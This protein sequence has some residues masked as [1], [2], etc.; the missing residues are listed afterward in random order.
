[1]ESLAFSDL[2]SGT[3]NLASID[4]KSRNATVVFL[5][6]Y[7]SFYSS[8]LKIFSIALDRCLMITYPFKHRIL[9]SKGKI[10][11]WIVFAWFLSSIHSLKK[12][13]QRSDSDIMVLRSGIA[14][15]LIILTAMLYF[16]IKTYFALRL[17]TSKIHVKGKN[18]QSSC[19]HV[20]ERN[21]KLILKA[22]VNIKS[23]INI[24][25][26][27]ISKETHNKSFADVVSLTS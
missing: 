24:K 16:I 3:A 23:E 27:N 13:L 14:L 11:V 6:I 8:M 5:F 10:A 21:F 18:Y 4:K 22:T 20:Q 12:V 26:N 19:V 25:S 9:M 17:L 15:M 7:F 2:V 1:L